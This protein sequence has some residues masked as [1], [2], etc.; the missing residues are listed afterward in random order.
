[1]ASLPAFL[2]NESKG[3]MVTVIKRTVAV[4]VLVGILWSVP[5]IALGWDGSVKGTGDLGLRLRS[6][7]WSS[8]IGILPEGTKV[9]VVGEDHDQAGEL[10]YHIKT[11]DKEG[12]VYAEHI[13]GSGKA[14]TVDGSPALGTSSGVVQTGLA[15]WYGPGFHG[16][17]MANGQIFNMYDPTTTASNTFPMGTWLRVT[18][19]Y[20]GA[21]VVVQV[22]DRGGF[23][24]AVVLDLSMAAFASIAS[25][26]SGVIPVSVEVMS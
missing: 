8:V 10:W 24:G 26:D 23:G 9:D 14:F 1:M 2:Q 22:R 13:S 17:G 3:R 6:G 16:N 20:N 15:T 11:A 25:L 7:V 12:W 4:L 21:S 19:Q 5:T 18:N